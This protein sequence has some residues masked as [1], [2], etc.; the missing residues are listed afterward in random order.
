MTQSAST[1]TPRNTR[2]DL[3][4]TG[5]R[6]ELMETTQ[7]VDKVT[8]C[9]YHYSFNSNT[10]NNELFGAMFRKHCDSAIAKNYATSETKCRYVACRGLA[11]TFHDLL[12]KHISNEEEF[13]L[14]FDESHNSKTHSKQMDV[15]VMAWKD[16]WTCLSLWV[17]PQPLISTHH[18]VLLLMVSVYET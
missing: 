8:V 17:M 11:P 9:T 6:R 12:L 13:V 15:H 3:G 2:H 16:R 4:A 18:F 10:G 5:A 14:L 1:P 7:R